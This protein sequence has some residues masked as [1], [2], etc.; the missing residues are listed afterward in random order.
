LYLI[1]LLAH[2]LGV[3]MKKSLIVISIFC[4]VSI[5]LVSY[6][7]AETLNISVSGNGDGSTNTVTVDQTSTVTVQQSNNATVVNDITSNQNT[8][9]NTV[10]GNSGG[11]TSIHTG[12]VQTN[13][14]VTNNL[15]GN[16]AQV[17]N[18]CTVRPTDYPSN[19]PT[20]TLIPGQP[21]PTP[22]TSDHKDDTHD[23]NNHNDGDNTN[24][25]VGGANIDQIRT[26]PYTGSYNNVIIQ[27]LGFIC[28]ALG[29]MFFQKNK[30]V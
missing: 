29:S 4:L 11:D 26:L 28:V 30:S 23:D 12:D 14:H 16:L 18:C 7:H 3:R 21:T 5:F 27:G 2:R 19:N 1:K 25:G 8:G 9:G 17:N 24:N 6:A 20:P 10:N 15:N 13:V 22:T